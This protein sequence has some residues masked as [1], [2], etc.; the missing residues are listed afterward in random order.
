MVQDDLSA[1]L[2]ALARVQECVLL[3]LE[4]VFF[5]RRCK[6]LVPCVDSYVQE[7]VCVVYT[8]QEMLAYRESKCC[9][10]C[11]RLSQIIINVTEGNIDSN[12]SEDALEGRNNLVSSS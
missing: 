10:R 11:K 4:C 8:E 5:I 12:E 7:Y 6:K 3:L 9:R 2:V 1:A